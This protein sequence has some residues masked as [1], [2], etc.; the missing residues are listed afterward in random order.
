M[1]SSNKPASTNQNRTQSTSYNPWNLL[2]SPRNRSESE[3]STSSNS[4]NC[5]SVSQFGGLQRQSSKNN[6]DY[7]Y[8]IWR[9]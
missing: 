5:P 4:Q 7:L 3:S 9:S 6:E 1:D 2:F 8:M